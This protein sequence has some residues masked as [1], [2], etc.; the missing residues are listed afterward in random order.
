MGERI[1]IVR[2]RPQR[3]TGT[4]TAMATAT[5]SRQRECCRAG[6]RGWGGCASAFAAR[7]IFLSFFF[8][9][10]CSAVKRRCPAPPSPPLHPPVQ[11]LLNYSPTRGASPRDFRGVLIFHTLDL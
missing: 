8:T 5:G 4:V 6:G 11:L 3:P 1:A 10:S 2:K 9:L 7:R